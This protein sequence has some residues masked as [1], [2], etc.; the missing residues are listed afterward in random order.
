MNALVDAPITHE[1]FR[2]PIEHCITKILNGSSIR[3][4]P[5]GH[6]VQTENLPTTLCS[7]ALKTKRWRP[8]PHRSGLRWEIVESVW[9]LVSTITQELKWELNK[10]LSH[11]QSQVENGLSA[12]SE[13]T[14]PPKGGG[15]FQTFDRILHQEE[16]SSK[17]L[18]GSPQRGGCPRTVD[19]IRT[20]GLNHRQFENLLGDCNI[21]HGEP[22]VHRSYWL[23]RIGH[24]SPI[25]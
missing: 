16:F 8:N 7:K 13:E 20:R 12:L 15:N 24:K 25:R 9:F 2:Y 11:P 18:N 1:L 23:H 21:S 14:Q 22:T 19:F 4:L 6:T 10:L 5:K 3:G 17:S